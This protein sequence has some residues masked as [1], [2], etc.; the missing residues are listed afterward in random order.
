MFDQSAALAAHRRAAPG[1]VVILLHDDPP[2]KLGR[3][4]QP[5]GPKV[6]AVYKRTPKPINWKAESIA[7]C[8]P[9]GV[10]RDQHPETPH[11]R[12]TRLAA[13]REQAA[14]RHILFERMRRIN[15]KRVY[16]LRARHAKESA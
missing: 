10:L 9:I 14:A 1:R 7:L 3:P 8:M 13:W 2:P 4:P 16:R 6:R 5:K 15:R 12:K 11:E